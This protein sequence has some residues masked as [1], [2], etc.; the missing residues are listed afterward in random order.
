[1]PP[2]NRTDIPY[3]LRTVNGLL[4]GSFDKLSLSST[5]PSQSL[6]TNA[7]NEIV[8]IPNT[9]SG[10]NVL[11][12]NPVL[13]NPNISTLDPSSSV[14]TDGAK[15]LVSVP[16][17]GS[18]SNVLQTSPSLITPNIGTAT[19]TDLTITNLNAS[20]AVQT[21]GS[22][23]LI[24]IENTGTGRNVLQTGPEFVNPSLN[25]ATCTTLRINTLPTNEAV[26]TDSNSFLVTVPNTGTGSNVLQTS[27]SL[28]TP[29][30]G[31]ATGTSLDTTGNIETDQILVSNRA[32]GY[33]IVVN[34]T[35]ESTSTITGCARFLG[36]VGVGGNVNAS[37]AFDFEATLE[38]N[39]IR[40][41]YDGATAAGP[42]A[43]DVAGGIYVHG[44]IRSGD[45]VK[46]VVA[47]ASLTNASSSKTTGSIRAE[48]GVGCA[49]VWVDDT[50]SATSKTTAA[51]KCQGGVGC[52]DL[53]VNTTARVPTITD[54][55]T[56]N[57]LSFA[58]SRGAF[59][60][61]F[62]SYS[63][64]TAAP[65]A[66]AVDPWDS[67]AYLSQYGYYT[68]IGNLVFV[69]IRVATLID[70]TNNAYTDSTRFP[71]IEGLPFRYSKPEANMDIPVIGTCQ[72]YSWPNGR[73]GGVP[74]A[75]TFTMDPTFAPMLWPN[76]YNYAPTNPLANKT[77]DGK[78]ITFE[79]QWV[80]YGPTLVETNVT[81]AATEN[82]H[83][84]TSG[85]NYVLEFELNLT[86][87]TDQ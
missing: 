75:S 81:T 83:I 69:H 34:S 52:E 1:M 25:S 58:Y 15:N 57:T 7:S 79:N 10:S 74:G 70:G 65:S 73:V 13:V 11:Q 18:G 3:P 16:N 12:T 50:T 2:V 27:P 39:Y 9:G 71:V 36:G 64:D 63:Y 20:E 40:S 61:S 26:Q 42:H 38:T 24:S 28:V 29:D 23:N 77:L 6:Q 68:R 53:Y 84:L 44:D 59:T 46:T 4:N 33:G 22:K 87:Y 47:T 5:S 37:G 76:L 78:T 67:P 30:I 19:A 31:V 8:S 17:T 49:N 32:T 85:T 62:T 60:P 14:Q 86:Y 21:D 72:R 51:V 55:S 35:T 41:Q 82:F 80:F 66:L 54:L 56:L 43:L 45:T 48:G